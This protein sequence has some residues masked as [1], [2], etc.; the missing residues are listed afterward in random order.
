[1]VKLTGKF[2]KYRRKRFVKKFRARTRSATGSNKRQKVLVNKTRVNAGLGFPKRMTMTHKYHENFTL[3]AGATFGTYNISCNSMYDPNITG[4]GHQPY[5]FDQMAALYDHYVVIGTKITVKI[6]PTTAS[7]PLLVGVY[8][9]DDGTVTPTDINTCCEQSK[10]R[11][12]TTNLSGDIVRFDLKWSAKKAFGGSILANT[13]LQ[14][15]SAASPTENQVYTIFAQ[16]VD[17]TT[18]VSM[19]VEILVEYIAVW[20]ELKDI[21]GS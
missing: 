1:M 6:I 7:Q 9:N 8:L 2:G 5:Y 11:W 10:A 3:T 18:N 15:T 17:K 16:H 12:K 20:K 13:E 4:T 19:N 14:G 21:G